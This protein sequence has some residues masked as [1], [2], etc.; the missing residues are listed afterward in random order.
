VRVQTFFGPPYRRY[1]VVE[2]SAQAQRD[3]GV[4]AATDRRLAGVDEAA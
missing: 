4:E 1:F 3:V 2:A